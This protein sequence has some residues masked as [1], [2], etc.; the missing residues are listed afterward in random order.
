M[1]KKS[2]GTRVDTS[3]DS[4]NEMDHN[5]VLQ[6]VSI[7]VFILVFGVIDSEYQIENYP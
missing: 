5:R 3:L 2:P 4:T 1:V 6:N 7:L